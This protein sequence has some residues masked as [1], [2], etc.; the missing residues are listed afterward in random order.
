MPIDRESETLIGLPEA[1]RRTVGK[2]NLSTLHRWRLSGCRG[3]RLETILIGGRRYTSL[4]AME[5]F[6]AAINGDAIATPALDA[7]R[8]LQTRKT[9]AA[10]RE[11]HGIK[12]PATA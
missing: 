1:S 4:Q 6:F 3:H 7:A 10:L 12:V 9:A 8:E 5:R 2:P 11:R